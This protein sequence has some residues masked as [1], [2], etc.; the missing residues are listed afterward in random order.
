MAHR[1]QRV[2]NPIVHLPF[3]AL[4]AYVAWLLL[5]PPSTEQELLGSLG[6]VAARA[7]A[8]FALLAAA[9]S[10]RTQRIWS[11]LGIGAAL[12]ATASAIDLGIRLTSG[13]PPT[14]PSAADLIY[15]A[16]YLAA[17]TGVAIYRQQDPERF[18]RVREILDIA[19]LALAVGSLAWI[20]LIRPALGV[21]LGDPISFVWAAIAPTLNSILVVLFVRLAM[22]STSSE[23]AKA[24][25]LL[26]AAA[27]ILAL[28]D[29]ANA[30]VRLLDEVTTTGLIEVGRITAALIMMSV[31]L[32]VRASDS[33]G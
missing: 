6:V 15:L 11:Y 33:Q 31:G 23:R 18:G 1:V 10:Y 30:Y 14:L 28:V 22:R 27:A 2:W 12:W 26:A 25:L 3:L 19:I 9:R 13:E 8:A 4:T 16:G 5:A 29:L 24:F 32:R 20:I 21:G 17:L 7:A